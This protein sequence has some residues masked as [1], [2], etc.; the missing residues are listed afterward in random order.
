MDAWCEIE[1][2]FNFEDEDAEHSP[3][4]CE[5][6]LL[7]LLTSFLREVGKKKNQKVVLGTG[8]FRL[9]DSVVNSAGL[10]SGADWA[11]CQRS[12]VLSRP[13]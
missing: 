8:K 2:I 4:H 6:E 11:E 3:E 12:A 5:E 7:S 9:L 1:S 13:Q 10:T